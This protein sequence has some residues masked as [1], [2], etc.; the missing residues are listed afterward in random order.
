LGLTI[1]H[2]ILNMHKGSLTY[3][4]MPNQV[5]RFTVTLPKATP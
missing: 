4:P 1:V 3:T 5:N 2:R